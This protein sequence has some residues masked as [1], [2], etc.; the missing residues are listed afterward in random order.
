MTGP[1]GFLVAFVTS[2]VL[3]RPKL[4]ELEPDPKKREI[5]ELKEKLRTCEVARDAARAD[6]DHSD[7]QLRALTSPYQPS[8]VRAEIENEELRRLRTAHNSLLHMF[9]QEQRMRLQLERDYIETEAR[10]QNLRNLRSSAKRAQAPRHL[11]VPLSSQEAQR[12]MRSV[13]AFFC[14]CAPGR[15]EIFARH[16]S[17]LGD[18]TL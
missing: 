16:G 18:D 5:A 4:P 17:I 10:L 2:A 11:P 1:L 9:A 7:A 15:H 14:N 3:S 12:L 8:A 6:R 13:D